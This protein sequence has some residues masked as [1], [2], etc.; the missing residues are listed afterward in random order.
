MVSGNKKEHSTVEFINMIKQESDAR[1]GKVF[2]NYLEPIDL[3]QYITKDLGSLI[4]VGDVDRIGLQLSRYIRHLDQKFSPINLN[5]VVA[6]LLLQADFVSV[7]VDDLVFNCGKIWKYLRASG[8]NTMITLEPNQTAVI[9]IVKKLGFKIGEQKAVIE[10]KKSKK[11]VLLSPKSD[12][13]TL[14]S[15]NYYSNQMLQ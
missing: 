2:I 9:N 5:M 11:I 13:K 7:S 6:T 4:T 15:L 3:R 12:R 14:L 1:L 8:S 10:G